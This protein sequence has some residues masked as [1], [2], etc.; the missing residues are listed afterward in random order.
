MH[1][2]GRTSNR[3]EKSWEMP[4]Q[5]RLFR[6]PLCLLVVGVAGGL[7]LSCGAGNGI[8]TDTPQ[9]QFERANRRYDAGRYLEAT[10]TFKTLLARFPGSKYAEPARFYLGQ[11]YL[12]DKEYL[13]AEMEFERII[14]DFPRGAHVEVATFMLAMCA[15]ERRR[16]IPFDQTATER[17][18]LLFRAYMS[19]YPD[20]ASV[21]RAREKL[22]ECRSLLAEKL[23]AN[24]TLYLKLSDPGAARL[25]FEE[26]LEKYEDLHWADWALVGIAKSYEQ[27]RNWTKAAEMYEGVVEREGDAEAV[28]LAA[29]RL[30]KVRDRIGDSENTG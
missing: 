23:H 15:Y 28:G 9:S 27:E 24:G 29:G 26:I 12:K 3:E 10:E 1:R 2:G 19:T 21:E 11:C 22:G 16:P 20:G 14:K 7:V 4:K 8:R 17:A 13:L 30:R 6:F 25:S 5:K 18:I